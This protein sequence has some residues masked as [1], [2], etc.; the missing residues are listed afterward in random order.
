[1]F[2]SLRSRILL[3]VV[4][5]VIVTVTGIIYFVQKET[6]KTFSELQDENARNMLNAVVLNVENQYQS[7]IFHEK[8]ALE[9]RKSDLKHIVTV[10]ITTLDEIYKNYHQGEGTYAQAKQRAIAIVKNMKY[11][12]G[13]GY[14][15]INDMGRPIPKMIMHATIPSLDNTILDDPKFN[16]ALGIKQNLFQAFVDACLENGS[17]YVDYLWPKPTK[18]GF[19]PEQPKISYVALF[20][21]WNWVV[22][23]G[24]YIDDIEFDSRKRRRAIVREL[25]YSFSKV[26]LAKSGYMYI[27]NGQQ[28]LLVHPVLA[29]TDG[30]ILKNPSTGAPL[31]KELMVASNTPEK[32]FEYVWDKPLTHKGEYKFLKRAYIEYFAPLDWYIASSVYV[33]EIESVSRVLVE[34]IFYLSIFFLGL[35]IFLSIL[36]SKTLTNPLRRL[37]FSAEGIE[38]SGISSITMP[39]TG[40]KETKALGKILNK[41]IHSISKSINEKEGLLTALQDAHDKLEQRVKERTF[42]LEAINRQLIQAKEKAE[43][44]NQTKSEFLANMSHEIRTP[45]NGVVGMIG[46]LLDTKLTD[47]QKHY[48]ETVRVSGESL[49]GLINDILDFSKIEAGKL[50]LEVL[51]FDLETMMED[52]SDALAVQAHGKGLEFVCGISPEVPVMLKGDPGR[53]RQ[54]LTNLMGN[55]IKFTHAGEVAVHVSMVSDVDDSVMLRFLVRD[56]GIGIPDDKV[57]LLFAKFTQV[58]ASTT[59]QFGGTGLGLAISKQLVEMMGGQIGVE[60]IQGKG[61]D[62]WFTVKLGKLVQGMITRSLSASILSGVR[63]L[64]VDNNATNREILNIRMMSWNMRVSE[65]CDGPMALELLFKAL[66]ENDPFMVA[67]IDMQMPGMDGET[68]GRVIHQDPRLVEVHMV[69]LTSLRVR[70]D[71]AVR[72]TDLGF[73]GYLTKPIRYKELQNILTLAHMKKE[74]MVPHP[75]VSPPKVRETLNFFDGNKLRILLVE[76]NI[77]NQQVAL[78]MLK[79]LGLRTDAVADG[80]EALNALSTIP[81]DLVLM[82]CQMPEMDGYEATRQIRNPESLVQ[83]HDI[84]VIAMTANAM[85]GDR[86]KCLEAG[87]NGYVSKPVNPLA[88]VEELEK[89]LKFVEDVPGVNLENQEEKVGAKKEVVADNSLDIFDPEVILENLT[90]DTKLARTILEAF[91]LDMPRQINALQDH[92]GVSK[93]EEVERQAHT[94]KGVAANVGAKSLEKLAF[95]VE[96]AVKAGDLD[97]VQNDIPQF[98]NLFAKLEE[99]MKAILDTWEKD[100][101]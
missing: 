54:V 8:T 7:L 78:G 65:S 97:A 18:D 73:I 79:K 75:M 23:T 26:R 24:A 76:D 66:E 15:W 33:D 88:L 84:P 28:Q 25:Q 71:D 68:L 64:I 40:T 29:G 91:L 9:M 56:T 96:K 42:D 50:E 34:K 87:M 74:E 80:R 72:F 45:M 47:D 61:T 82:D 16:C 57:D 3:I 60:S 38:K 93:I 43:I 31:L 14:L 77:I 70:G 22:G 27:F 12:Q 92:F 41:M 39:L 51:D 53:L 30:S 17:G 94:I 52:F 11:D 49:L 59:R 13:V 101:L 1:M 21:P 2:Q 48:A 6:M 44:A 69:L 37:M 19:T 85:A 90:G 99:V 67:V 46:L 98:L 86:E 83:N 10:A 89:W 62:L 32:A 5:I 55:A 20:K 100:E 4:S 35:S 81:Y 36:F 95:K 63:A 58:D